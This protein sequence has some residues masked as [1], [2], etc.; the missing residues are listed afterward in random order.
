MIIGIIGVGFVGGAI[1]KSFSE[2]KIDLRVY[3]KYKT[4]VEGD[5]AATLDSDLIFLCLPTLFS[6]D[7]KTYD[8]TPTHEVCQMLQDA[9]YNGLVIIKSTVISNTSDQL[10]KQYGLKIIHN[11]EF[12]TARTAYQ[13]F[14]QQKHIVLG[15]T[16]IITEADMDLINNFYNE[17]FPSAKITECSALESETMKIFVN[18]FYAMKVQIFNE[19]YLLC[20]K[21]DCSFTQVRKMMLANGWINP[22][23]TDVPGPD[24]LLSYGGACF[25]K[26]TQALRS[27]FNHHDVMHGILDSCITER[28]YMRND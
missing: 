18:S 11:P 1:M 27:L 26:D 19:F 16:S 3:D 15:K 22:M 9:E 6:E 2:K 21:M 23:H 7:L 10:T 12:L 13:D 8:L 14:Q 24:G 17:Y 5:F 4:S 28:D 20:Q 25:P